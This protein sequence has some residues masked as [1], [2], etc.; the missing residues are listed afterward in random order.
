MYG[1]YFSLFEYG[2]KVFKQQGHLNGFKNSAG[3]KDDATKSLSSFS[4]VVQIY[5]VPCTSCTHYSP[6]DR[7]NTLFFPTVTEL[8][9]LYYFL[10]ISISRIDIVRTT[11][12][13][14]NFNIG[15]HIS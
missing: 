15:I 4:S 8:L 11:Y 3:F 1:E 2:S 14:W 10:E 12:R 5:Y 7:V 6:R 13:Y 9:L